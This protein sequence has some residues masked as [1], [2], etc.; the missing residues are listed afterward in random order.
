MISKEIV[1]ELVEK[2]SQ[3]AEK[4]RNVMVVSYQSQKKAISRLFC[5]LASF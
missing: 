5:Q 4:Q 1:N 2:A 3:R